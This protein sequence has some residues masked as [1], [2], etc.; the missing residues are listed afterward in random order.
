MA[1][2]PITQA[3]TVASA[4]TTLTYPR[5][6]MGGVYIP[7][8]KSIEGATGDIAV[9]TDNTW[10]EDEKYHWFVDRIATAISDEFDTAIT[11]TGAKTLKLSATDATGSQAVY[12]GGLTLASYSKHAP[13]LKPSTEYTLNC[14]VKTTTAV[15]NSI[16]L[17]V[18]VF[19]TAGTQVGSTYTTNK[20]SGTNDWTLCTITFNSGVGGVYGRIRC[21]MYPAGAIM[22]AYFD[23]N[24][25]TLI[26]TGVSRNP[27][28]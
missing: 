23:V 10:I 12:I 28:V 6:P 19:N 1:R 20:L 22:D 24:S 9:T 21:T 13:I 16:Y 27:V 18:L 26:E 17:D 4:R 5:N 7:G 14:Y 3:R 8:A 2:N 15:T 11:R 25:M